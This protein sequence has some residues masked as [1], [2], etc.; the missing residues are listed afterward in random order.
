MAEGE[1]LKLIIARKWEKRAKNIC[2]SSDSGFFHPVSEVGELGVEKNIPRVRSDSVSE[3]FADWLGS[4]LSHKD[5]H[6]TDI[7]DELTGRKSGHDFFFQFVQLEQFNAHQGSEPDKTVGG[8]QTA[9]DEDLV[10][11]A[12][13]QITETEVREQDQHRVV[14]GVGR[15]EPF[16]CKHV[17]QGSAGLVQGAS[18]VTQLAVQLR[19]GVGQLLRQHL[20]HCCVCDTFP[21]DRGGVGAEECE[22]G[23]ERV[24]ALLEESLSSRP[25]ALEHADGRVF[26]TNEP[27]L[28]LPSAGPASRRLQQRDSAHDSLDGQRIQEVKL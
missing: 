11:P 13:R 7:R 18:F 8:V 5:G 6:V 24:F 19:Q 22:L 25:D 17:L 26:Q 27:Q 21:E 20:G 16:S 1:G 23:R 28:F 10:D 15:S 3:A 14:A 4:K 12:V 2:A 9:L